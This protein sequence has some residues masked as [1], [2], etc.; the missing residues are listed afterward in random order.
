METEC[1]NFEI[2]RMARLLE[3]SRAAY[4]RWCSHRDSPSVVNIPELFSTHSSNSLPAPT[5]LTVPR[6]RM[7]ARQVP[8]EVAPP[9]PVSPLHLRTVRETRFSDRDLRQ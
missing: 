5:M 1:A 2:S 8:V 9:G 6:P 4:Y 3:V 7:P